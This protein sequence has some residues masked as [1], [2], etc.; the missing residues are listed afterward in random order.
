MLQQ[1]P[2]VSVDVHCHGEALRRMSAFH[3]FC[4]EWSSTVFFSVFAIHF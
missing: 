3:A 1:L 2:S 4:S